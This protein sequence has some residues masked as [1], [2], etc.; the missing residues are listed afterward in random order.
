MIVQSDHRSIARFCGELRDQTVIINRDYQ[1][2]PGVW[3]TDAQSF[4][5]ET[6]LLG[7]PIPKLTLF[8]HT[9][10]GSRTTVTELVDGQQRA[11]AI[12][13]FFS[14]DLKL[15][16]TL[17]F[18]PDAA[19]LRYEELLPEHQARF[20]TYA[21]GFDSLVNTSPAQIREIFRRINSYEMP[22]N[23]EEQRHARYQGAFKWLVYRLAR[24]YG[25][26][27]KDTGTFTEGNLVR[28]A[29]MKLIAEVAHALRNGIKTTNRVSLDNLYKE[30]EKSFPERASR[31]PFGQKLEKQ[32]SSA[33]DFVRSL[34]TLVG[35]PL[36]K[37]Y[38]MYSLLLAIIHAKFNIDTLRREG[39]GGRGLADIATVER[40]LGV[41]AEV[42]DLEEDDPKTP[43][44]RRFWDAFDSRT[45]VADQRSARFKAFL[46][47]VSA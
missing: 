14:N 23:Y 33:V 15:S 1:R 16:R 21:L 30:F 2:L 45:N 4:L 31:F 17:E 38:S 19:G 35:T 12:Y 22:L 18:V 7:Y 34:E 13:A 26:I 28:M 9:D 32:F 37:Q 10:I 8:E 46:K 6:I 41:L 40:R 3:P 44:Q 29:D 20:M 43:E 36:V 5:I 25:E 24:K 11:T 27:L 42:L 39:R 47:A